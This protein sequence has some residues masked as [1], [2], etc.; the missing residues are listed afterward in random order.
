M[1]SKQL[2]I[3]KIKQGKHL[4]EEVNSLNHLRFSQERVSRLIEILNFHS[5]NWILGFFRD[6]FVQD[7][8]ELNFSDKLEVAESDKH[9]MII[10]L[11]VI[12]QESQ[13]L[14]SLISQPIDLQAYID[15]VLVL[16]LEKRDISLIPHDNYKL[17]YEYFVFS[18]I[19]VS[20]TL[21]FS[22]NDFLTLLFKEL[23]TEQQVLYSNIS[24]NL[25]VLMDCSII[26]SKNKE[27]ADFIERLFIKKEYIHGG[28]Y[29]I[30]VKA[31]ELSPI[32]LIQLFKVKLSID[33]FTRS[34]NYSKWL[35][36]ENKFQFLAEQFAKINVLDVIQSDEYIEFQNKLEAFNRYCPY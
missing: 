25:L 8:N 34:T 19:D 5:R 35:N 3:E 30:L 2:L 15:F 27:H 24:H 23:L 1:K 21:H 33:P 36:E 10:L 7:F 22:N 9:G 17:M 29:Q 20:E 6:E 12:S 32:F 31:I 4:T 18:E 16:A 26:D 14:A 13:G 28:I 11:M